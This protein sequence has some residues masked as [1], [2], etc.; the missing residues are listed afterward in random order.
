MYRRLLGKIHNS[1]MFWPVQNVRMRSRFLY[2]FADVQTGPASGLKIYRSHFAV[3][4][5]QLNV[6]VER[7]K[8]RRQVFRSWR[9]KAQLHSMKRDEWQFE[10]S[11]TR[12]AN[13]KAQETY[14]GTASNVFWSLESRK[15]QYGAVVIQQFPRVHE[16]L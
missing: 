2:T 7:C 4:R 14:V 12:T 9:R 13:L 1:K 11:G 3:L 10:R 5:Q 6:G 15:T 8:F 16:I